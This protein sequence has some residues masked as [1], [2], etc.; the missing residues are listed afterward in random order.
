MARPRDPELDERILRAVRDLTASKGAAAVTIGGVASLAGV[1]RPTIYRRWH[2]RAELLFAAQTNASVSTDFPDTG[3]LRGDLVVAVGHLAATMAAADRSV[4]GEQFGR[5]VA[6]AD[7]AEQVWVDRWIPDR[8]L[9]VGL[10][11]RA[12]TRGEVDA[13]VDADTAVDDLVAICLFRVCFGHEQLGADDVESIVDRV[14]GDAI[15]T[16]C[17]DQP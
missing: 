8:Q 3:S 15:A 9:V 14:L 12:R 5:M 16:R 11:D 2:T 13:N 6:D 10:W 1:S 17:R 4:L 7:F